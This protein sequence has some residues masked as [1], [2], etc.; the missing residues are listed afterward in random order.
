MNMQHH[1]TVVDKLFEHTDKTGLKYVPGNKFFILS[2]IKRIE[3]L[4][5]ENKELRFKIDCLWGDDNE[6]D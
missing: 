4:E 1:L 2:L 6:E 3:A 5:A